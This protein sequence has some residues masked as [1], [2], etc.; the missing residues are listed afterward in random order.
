MNPVIIVGNGIA[1][2]T[3]ARTL[4]KLSDVPIVLISDEALHFFS[5]TALMYVF[6]GHMPWRDI[7]PYA[8]DF[9]PKNRIELCRDRVSGFDHEHRTV[10]LVSGKVLNY[11]SLVFAI[12]SLP[13]K[14]DVDGRNLKGV[15]VLYSK[16]DLEA[17]E[18]LAHPPGQGEI[19]TTNAPRAIV[20]GAGLIGVELAEMLRY[21][22][23]HVTM[24]VRD[25]WYWK[26]N[27]PEPEARIIEHHLREH[28]VE[29]KFNCEVTEF[30]GANGMLEAV[31]ITT[32]EHLQCELAGVS[33]GVRPNVDIL[34]GGPLN[35]DRGIV[36]DD[37]LRTNLA[38]VYAAGDCAQ[39]AVPRPHRRAIEP[40]WYTGRMMGEALG[41]TLAQ[42]P[43][44]Y[45]PGNWFNS[46]KFFDI[47]YQIYG[48]VPD[49]SAKG[50]ETM[51]WQDAASRRALRIAYDERHVFVGIHALGVRLRHEV[52]DR[53]L[54]EG[55]QVRDV[56]ANIGEL[57]FDPEFSKD[58]S[59]MIIETWNREQGDTLTP[60]RSRLAKLFGR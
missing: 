15:Q 3:T 43:A 10:S 39:L 37:H 40:V 1:G 5:R 2:V 50:I 14:P 59:P 22:R 41:Q 30:K 35:I 36:V 49:S 16:Q 60:K 51:Y 20:T 4:R 27:L 28:G 7:E 38:H 23:Y 25:A 24:L 33:I 45:M 21:R 53:W 17:L 34:R 46:A 57:R 54:T 12:G 32:G 13:R 42:Q 56:V 18:A 8:A 48:Y 26:G 19:N 55:R 31:T 58:I 29:L 52:A 9:W 44:P 6:M 11:S 47:E